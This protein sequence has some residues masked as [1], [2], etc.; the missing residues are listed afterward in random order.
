VLPCVAVCCS[1]LQYHSCTGTGH[2]E[3]VVDKHIRQ[4]HQPAL[5]QLKGGGGSICVGLHVDVC[6]YASWYTCMSICRTWVGTGA[7]MCMCTCRCELCV[8]REMFRKS[9]PHKMRNKTYRNRKGWK[10]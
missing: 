5:G 9:Q 2:S 3:G 10:E 1:V 8:C 6:M 4:K 7:V